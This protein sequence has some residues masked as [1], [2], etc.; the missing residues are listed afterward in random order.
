M[1]RPTLLF[2]IFFLYF[3][4]ALA[5][6][7]AMSGKIIITS[8]N[9]KTGIHTNKSGELRVNVSPKNIRQ[10]KA[11]GFVLYSDFG[12]DGN[13][14][15]D[16]I[17]AIAATHA[18]ANQYTL[19]VKADNAATYYIGGKD[20]TVAIRTNTDFGT[21]TFIIDDTDVKNRNASVFEVGS[22]LLSFKP[23]GITSLRRNQE[24]LDIA[25]P[26]NCLISVTNTEVK[27]YIR[28]GPN[29][30]SGSSQTDIF[31]ADKNGKTDSNTPILWDFNTITDITAVP[32]DDK[33]L[34]I[35]GGHFI[36]IANNA[37]SK[38]TYYSRNILVRRSNVVIDGLE[39]R[40]NGEGNNGA[41]Y[42][43]FITISNCA[44]ITV[45]NSILTGH[46]TYQT[47]GSAGKP[48]S[49]G[50]YDISVN[51]AL[52]VSFISC[53]QTNDI[54]DNRFWGIMGS[55]YCK[56]L[57]YDS[58]TLSRFDAHKGVANATIRNSV[59]GHMGINAIGSGTLRIENTTIYGRSIVNLRNDYG[60][61]WQGSFIILNCTLVTNIQ[62]SG[63]PVL[64]NGAYS[65][66]HDFGY[67]CYMPERISIENLRIE[68]TDY[69]VDYKGP[70]I[71]AHFN[72]QNI[73][74]SYY[75][76]FP[77]VITKEV[78]LR[79]VTTASGMS[80][81]FSSNPFM[82]RNVKVTTF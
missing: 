10:F 8:L 56:N 78:T 34:S 75:E 23:E 72:P 33:T 79:N 58:C 13:G 25:L 54:K 14:K 55:N 59:L 40:I 46:K 37:E 1:I 22:D 17:D 47:I 80:L 62:R 81:R 27:Q 42:S 7:G 68:D 11:K 19:L 71:F 74:S 21:A 77:Y 69:T 82:F 67:T 2:F 31:I 60:S 29:Q 26:A 16:D 43:G 15:T 65:G 48:V 38:Y 51:S 53:S 3:F 66:M 41:P 52:N 6:P 5:Q 44:Y 76:K 39:H 12:A 20:R 35:T 4:P 49:M 57:L 50:S 32:I 28:Y 18:F 45:K 73:D 30:D 61:S 64:I 24:K 36:T 9:E 63:A 70:A